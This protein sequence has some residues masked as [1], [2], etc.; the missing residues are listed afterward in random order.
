MRNLLKCRICG[1]ETLRWKRK[2]GT[3]H[4]SDGF[5]KLKEHYENHHDEYLEKIEEYAGVEKRRE[6]NKD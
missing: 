4:P 6:R 2:K 1:W 5:E 3:K